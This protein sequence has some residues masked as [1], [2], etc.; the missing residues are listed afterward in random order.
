MRNRIKSKTIPAKATLLDRL[1]GA[2]FSGFSGLALGSLL[3]ALV[4]SRWFWNGP[5]FPF[6]YIE[7]FAGAMAILGFALCDNI[8]AALIGGL[9]ELILA[10]GR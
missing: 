10:A 4:V 8:I 5:A 9:V 1:G 3:W 2:A 6:L 7:Y